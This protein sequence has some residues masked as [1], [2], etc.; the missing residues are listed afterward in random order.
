MLGTLR[1]ECL[2][3]L[4]ANIRPH[5]HQNRARSQSCQSCLGFSGWQ[6][7]LVW[8]VRKQRQLRPSQ[9]WSVVATKQPHVVTQML[10]IPRAQFRRA[11]WLSGLADWQQSSQCRL[12]RQASLLKCS[13]K[14]CQKRQI[15]LSAACW[16]WCAFWAGPGRDRQVEP[17]TRLAVSGQSL[18]LPARRA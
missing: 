6:V 13:S 17:G 7:R 14:A 10:C 1:H 2:E 18:N 12:S 16:S 11:F 15:R 4:A 8:L 5:R 9:L 3:C